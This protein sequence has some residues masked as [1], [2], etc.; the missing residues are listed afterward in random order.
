[1]KR[2]RQPLFIEVHFKRPKMLFEPHVFWRSLAGADRTRAASL[3]LAYAAWKPGS[4]ST[5]SYPRLMQAMAINETAALK[6]S[7]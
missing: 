5:D 2:L 6:D 7:S 4:Y 1:M 3:G